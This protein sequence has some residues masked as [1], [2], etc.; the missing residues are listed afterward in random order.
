MIEHIE[1][2][3]KLLTTIVRAEFVSQK[4]TFVTPSEFN[5][6]VDSLFI[7]RVGG[8]ATFIRVTAS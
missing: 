1:C 2:D 5:L 7:L 8:K 3:R 6:Q 4:T